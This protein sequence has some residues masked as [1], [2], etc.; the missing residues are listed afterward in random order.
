MMG[1]SDFA[2]F[3]AW[4]V[5]YI[6]LFGVVAL[7]VAL[8][9]SRTLFPN[10]SFVL[11]FIYFFVFGASSVAVCFFLRSVGFCPLLTCPR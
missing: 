5:V 6:G 4:F 1:L 10:S 8:I 3:S 11:L 2:L 9:T 7:V